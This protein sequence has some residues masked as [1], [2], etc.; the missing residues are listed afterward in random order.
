[1]NLVG[2]CLGGVPMCHGAGGMATH[3]RFGART[4][5]ALVISGALCSA[6]A[7]S[8]PTLWQPCLSCFP[9]RSWV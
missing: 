4:G 1:M 5:G 3:I 7:S 6:W 8:L 9:R 2:A